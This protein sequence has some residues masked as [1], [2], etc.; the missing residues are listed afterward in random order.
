MAIYVDIQHEDYILKAGYALFGRD[1]DG[2]TIQVIEVY[3]K[4][5]DTLVAT[6]AQGNPVDSVMV[7]N[8]LEDLDGKTPM[9]EFTEED[10]EQDLEEE[11]LDSE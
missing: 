4:P 6:I 2:D 1:A 10:I 8:N 7:A 11:E 9:I 3:H 5:S